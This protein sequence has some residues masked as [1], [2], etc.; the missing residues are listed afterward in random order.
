MQ[1]WNDSPFSQT[2]ESVL[3]TTKLP[4]SLRVFECE[5]GIFCIAAAAVLIYNHVA[6]DQKHI[7]VMA[8]TSEQLLSPTSSFIVFDA[9]PVPW[10]NAHRKTC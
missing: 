1:N 2:L 5:C 6:A 3:D 4:T 8:E 10:T 7:H 9:L